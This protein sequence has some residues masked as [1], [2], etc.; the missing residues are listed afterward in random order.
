MAG[1]LDNG[2]KRIGKTNPL[3]AC[4]R[5]AEAAM[6]DRATIVPQGR[7][8]T[9][10]GHEWREESWLSKDWIICNKCRTVKQKGTEDRSVC[11]G[12]L[13]PIEKI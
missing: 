13:Y 3:D 4:A 11:P 1:F 12:A 8:V 2:R 7:M 10:A 6:T 9:P 5:T